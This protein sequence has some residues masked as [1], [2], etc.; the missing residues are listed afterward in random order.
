MKQALKTGQ[1]CL[2]FIAF[3]PITKLFMLP[4]VVASLAHNDGWITA[5]INLAL[6][7]VTLLIINL[8][9]AKTTLL[10]YNFWKARLEKSAGR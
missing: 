4:S 10:L 8:A 7:L 9:C 1:I 2:F 5:C 3:A 6:D